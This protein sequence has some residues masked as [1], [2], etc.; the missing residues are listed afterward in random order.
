MLEREIQH[1]KE[2]TKKVSEANAKAFKAA[3]PV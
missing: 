2:E 1:A 3:A